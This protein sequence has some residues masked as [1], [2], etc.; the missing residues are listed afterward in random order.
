MTSDEGLKP[1]GRTRQPHSEEKTLGYVSRSEDLHSV[2]RIVRVQ[3][4]PI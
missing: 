4:L 2:L 1:V 3:F